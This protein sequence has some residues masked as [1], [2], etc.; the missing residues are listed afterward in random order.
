MLTLLEFF[1]VYGVSKTLHEINP[2]QNKNNE[3]TLVVNW[4][5]KIDN[6]GETLKRYSKG[7]GIIFACCEIKRE[8][9]CLPS[10]L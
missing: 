3:L 4:T 6:Q 7:C 5:I 9:V 2:P 8:K 10:L 1:F